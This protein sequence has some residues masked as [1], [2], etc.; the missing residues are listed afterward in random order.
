MA[1]KVLIVSFY[2]PPAGGGGVQRPLKLARYLPELGIETH[3]LAPTDPRWIHSDPDLPLP[4]QARIH[5]ARYTGPRG[6][7]PAQELYGLT[8]L[9][10]LWRRA[11]LVPRRLVLPD[12]NSLWLATALPAALRIVRREK[13]DV[14]L[15]TSPPS[16]VHVLGAAVKR[17][18]GV[19]WIADLRDSI[20]AK[21]DRNVE[22]AL[23]RAKERGHRRVARRVAKRADAIVCVTPTIAEEMRALG[24]LQEIA[25]IPNGADIDDFAGVAYTPGKRFRITHTGSFF[26]RRNPRPFLSALAEIDAP[27]TARFVGDFRPAD[28]A[29]V[30]SLGL[31]ERL[32]LIPFRP[33]RE[34]VEL[35][36]DSEALLLLL[37]N[38]GG[39]G[40]DV[41]SGKLYEYLAARRPILAS[42]PPEGAAAE[43]VRSAGAGVVVP[44][45]DEGA[46]K[47]A[48]SELVERWRRGELTD[49]ELPPEIGERI[50]RK[51]RVR[52][53]AELIERTV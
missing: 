24:A 11:T 12:E 27:I 29:W 30:E 7:L 19:R 18:T 14:I 52:E 45:E 20:V 48:L 36:R 16:S 39:R 13:I 49:V 4:E 5:R 41:P 15:T 21:P 32:E 38:E 22:R 51:T 37:P 23:V 2:F 10:R 6:R 46:I 9:R 50:D 17:L 43:L 28:R 42:V 40:L 3:V 33:H 44:P 31:G 8:G 53:T 1:T 35:Q 34:A 25:V 47:V 26:G